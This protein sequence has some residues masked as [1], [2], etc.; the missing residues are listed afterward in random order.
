MN[1]ENFFPCT[2]REESYFIS[3]VDRKDIVGLPRLSII[4]SPLIN[5]TLKIAS[6]EDGF[7]HSQG[8]WEQARDIDGHRDEE[9]VANAS[10]KSRTDDE[11]LNCAPARSL[12]SVNKAA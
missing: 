9:Q 6:H 2:G 8:P 3:D 4:F 12:H 10:N 1:Q 11:A 7:R 5:A